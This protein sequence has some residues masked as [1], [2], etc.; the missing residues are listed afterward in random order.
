[1]VDKIFFDIETIGNDFDSFDLKTQEYLLRYAEDEKSIQKEKESLGL[2]P[3][4]GEII[5]ASLYSP[6]KNKGIVYY[7]NE[8]PN[9][10]KKDILVEGEWSFSPVKNESELLKKFWSAIKPTKQV[11]SFNGRAFDA[12]F[13]LVRS[14]VNRIK[15]SIDLMP[16]RFN[17]FH[18]DMM[19]Q[20]T[21]FGAVKKRFSLEMWCK[22]F[23]IPNPKEEIDGNMVNGLFKSKK[24]LDIAKYC[25]GDSIA[26]YNLY[27]IW[28]EFMQKQ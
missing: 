2:F 22:A 20:L 26:V 24:Y 19:E 27:K 11:V 3:L 10:S 12:P 5:A 1:M 28:K 17:D 6:D 9:N 25:K 7:R 15:P 4:T 14:A 18:L 23:G 16:A 21:F 8:N 13:V